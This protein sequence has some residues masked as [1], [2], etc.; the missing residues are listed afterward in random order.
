MPPK[1][2]A[3]ADGVDSKRIP[4]LGPSNFKPIA[5]LDG[6]VKKFAECNGT[7]AQFLR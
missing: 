4:L 3:V 6:I 7:G 1:F 5:V 2:Q